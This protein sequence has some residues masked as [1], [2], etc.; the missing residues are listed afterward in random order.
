MRG[1]YYFYDETWA[2][3]IGPFDTQEEARE[4]LL[5]Y[6]ESLDTPKPKYGVSG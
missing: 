3:D 4:H 6:A 2:N 5:K 1:K